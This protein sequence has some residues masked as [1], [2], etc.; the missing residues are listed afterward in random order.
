MQ[1]ASSASTSNGFVAS[2]NSAA[3]AS[4][5]RL[6]PR[7]GSANSSTSAS[8]STHLVPSPS[9]LRQLAS[10]Q[11]ASTSYR[12]SS[13]YSSLHT[14]ALPAYPGIS[15]SASNAQPVAT[16]AAHY[17][18]LQKQKQAALDSQMKALY[19]AE[20]RE[21]VLEY[22]YEME[23]SRS[24]VNINKHFFRGRVMNARQFL[25]T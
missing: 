16:A 5:S 17:S 11:Q 21:E 2:N 10:E 14:E 20:Y 24:C 4:V 3:S 8:V 22:M 19:E 12:T 18:K 7:S 13:S 1:V 6:S 15:S 23:V 9:P 25:V